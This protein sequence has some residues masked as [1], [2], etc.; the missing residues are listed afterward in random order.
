MSAIFSDLFVHFNFLNQDRHIFLKCAEMYLQDNSDA[1]CK[2]QC[3]IMIIC[4]IIKYVHWTILF[5][6]FLQHHT[7]IALYI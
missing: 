6:G 3:D 1:A 2:G 4:K 5:N 7:R